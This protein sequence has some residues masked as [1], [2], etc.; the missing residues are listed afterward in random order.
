MLADTGPT[1]SGQ[2]RRARNELLAIQLRLR[3]S[4]MLSR[5]RRRLSPEQTLYRSQRGHDL[6]ATMCP[7]LQGARRQSRPAQELYPETSVAV[8]TF[9]H[10]RLLGL[11][12]TR[13]Q[14]R[15]SIRR[16]RARASCC[17]AIAIAVATFQETSSSAE[18]VSRIPWS[19]LART[20]IKRMQR[21]SI[22]AA[23][24]VRISWR[25]IICIP[26][27]SRR[28][29][30]ILRPREAINLVSKQQIY[31]SYPNEIIL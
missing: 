5:A 23:S 26:K 19:P 1:Q 2:T 16:A 25:L 11:K 21:M 31:F 3:R 15:F 18:F 30:P 20:P 29:R 4:P 8:R 17:W 14:S 6:A 28:Q 10:F 12:D 24:N 13:H 27:V 7:L 22:I 9:S